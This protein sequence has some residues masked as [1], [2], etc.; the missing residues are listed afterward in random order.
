MDFLPEAA[1]G[2]VGLAGVETDDAV[3]E[4]CLKNPNELAGQSDLRH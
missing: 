4:F 3:G 2:G 1:A